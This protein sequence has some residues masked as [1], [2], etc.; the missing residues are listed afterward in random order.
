MTFGANLAKALVSSQAEMTDAVKDAKNPFFK[1][2]YADLNAVREAI[3]PA[4]TKNKLAVL[5]PVILLDSGK[6]VIRTTVLHESGENYTADTEVVCAKV[7]DPQAYGSAISYARRYGLQS[8]FNVGAVDDDAE[9]NMARKPQNTAASIN[10][11]IP[12]SGTLSVSGQA[13]TN[14]AVVSKEEATVPTSGG[15]KRKPKPTAAAPQGD[16]F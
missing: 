2:K 8:M 7:N 14:V 10:T 1:S 4:L 6:S 13:V 9:G 16:V 12:I 15:F 5:Q 3:M 11:N